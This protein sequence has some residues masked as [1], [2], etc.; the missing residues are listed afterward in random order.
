MYHWKLLAVADLPQHT[1]L[2][3]FYDPAD[4]QSA[5]WIKVIFQS[6]VITVL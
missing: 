3:P 1:E 4:M 5:I 2:S 6:P